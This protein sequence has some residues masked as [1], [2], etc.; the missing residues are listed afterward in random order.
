MH[1]AAPGCAWVGFLLGGTR[2]LSENAISPS[3][4]VPFTSLP[5]WTRLGVCLG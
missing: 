2:S 1:P 4:I 5:S 3:L